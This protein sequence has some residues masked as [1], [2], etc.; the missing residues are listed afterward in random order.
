[1][2]ENIIANGSGA[3]NPGTT[4]TIVSG[5]SLAHRR[6]LDQRQLA[7]IG[8]N[9]SDGLMWFQPTQQQLSALLQVSVP[10]LQLARTLSLKRRA[11]ILD[12]TDQT[13]FT[14][15]ML[16]RRLPLPGFKTVN[17]NGASTDHALIQLARKVGVERML[18]A[19]V[20]AERGLML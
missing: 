16:A 20:A 12:G 4:R 11:A 14:T 5:V 10:Y 2:V 18:A 15:L 1:M 7:V 17:G 3:V 19:A 6:D 8:A 13:P 9:V